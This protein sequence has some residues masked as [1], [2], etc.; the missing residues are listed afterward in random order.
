MI[1]IFCNFITFLL[2]FFHNFV[3]FPAIISHI[4]P[5][6]LEF[7]YFSL[8]HIFIFLS[9]FNLAGYGAFGYIFAPSQPS[10]YY[11]STHWAFSQDFIPLYKIILISF[12]ISLCVITWIK[13]YH[14]TLLIFY[15]NNFIYFAVQ[16]AENFSILAIGI[17]V[18][19]LI[20]IFTLKFVEVCSAFSIFQFI[21]I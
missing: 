14:I 9:T 1:I 8:A 3:T 16:L 12:I 20:T 11:F 7:P 6:D 5:L 10:L 15:S 18:Y 17:Q 21:F 2:L 13:V 4:F 19:S